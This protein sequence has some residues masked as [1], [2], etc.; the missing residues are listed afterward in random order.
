MTKPTIHQ[1]KSQRYLRHLRLNEQHIRVLESEIE[2]QQ[3]RLQ[4]NGVAGG[5]NV[6]A[7]MSGKALE[8]GFTRLYELCD[9]L[10]SDLIGYVEEREE[11]LKAIH[12]LEDPD[13]F[14]VLYLRY[15]E[16]LRFSSIANMLGI[17]ERTV[18]NIHKEALS[19]IYRY[20]PAQWR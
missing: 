17:S 5:E 3:S 14:I 16:A 19:D 1:K 7:S 2:L 15:F 20:I 10:D 13:H 8:E 18:F 12:C 4:L 9:S 6:N 11:G